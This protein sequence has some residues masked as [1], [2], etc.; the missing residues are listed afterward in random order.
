MGI[1]IGPF[2]T[3]FSSFNP[4]HELVNNIDIHFGYWH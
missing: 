3:S 2:P 4:N 1:E